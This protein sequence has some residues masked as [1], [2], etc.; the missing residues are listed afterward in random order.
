MATDDVRVELISMSHSFETW[1]TDQLGK[2]GLN[3]PERVTELLQ[4][5]WNRY[6]A[7]LEELAIRAID[8]QKLSIEEA[9]KYLQISVLD[10]REKLEFYHQTGDHRIDIENGVARLVSCNI[11]VWEVVR[12]FA[13]AQSL[14]ELSS[15][16]PG[17]P[18]SDLRAA[19]RYSERNVEE[20]QRQIDQFEAVYEKRYVG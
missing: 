11:A 4:V 20:I 5:L 19:L 15:R 1:Q 9:S 2:L 7:L 13:K 10:L 6:P 12:E 8:E 17:I 3:Y 18:M 16:F 14:E